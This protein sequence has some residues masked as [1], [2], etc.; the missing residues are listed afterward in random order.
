MRS[1][2]KAA[3][4]WRGAPEVSG[5]LYGSPGIAVPALK[6][7]RRRKLVSPRRRFLLIALGLSVAVH[8]AAALLIALLP[9]VLQ[10]PPVAREAGTVELLMV[11]HKGAQPSA[12]PQPVP[13]QAAR[14][15]SRPP[16][17]D[18]P[19]QPPAVKQ[20]AEPP[21]PP[22]KTP[23]PAREAAGTMMPLSPDV[24]APK[25]AEPRSPKP[26]EAAAAQTK[27]A[28]TAPA[29]TRP[30]ETAAAQP[31]QAPV[32]DLAGTESDSNAVALGSNIVP[33]SP[34]NRF[35]NRPPI[36]PPEAEISGEHGAVLVV[37][38]VSETGIASGVDVAQSS[39][40]EVLDR[41]AVD[42]VRKWRFRPALRQ[43]RAVPFDMPF[44]FVFEAN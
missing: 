31:R 40:V 2:H 36:Y 44:R 28:E 11:E 34:D 22:I 21:K 25:P 5:R 18:Q 27:P 41:A 17:V 33:A 9:R 14:S 12:A 20:A 37:I 1:P 32:F 3:N 7:I 30:A 24:A 38:H 29:R 15:Q 26:T 8:I 23:G 6:D 10:R 16:A 13:D 35:R 19:A 4:L 43:G 39:G 42:A